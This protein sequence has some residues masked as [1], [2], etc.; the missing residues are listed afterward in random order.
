M[1]ES[2]FTSVEHLPRAVVVHVLCRQL[3]KEEIG[4]LCTAIDQ[5][6]VIA[7]KLSFI[8]DMSKVDYAP[9]MAL[10]VLVGLTKEFQ[11]RG[12]RLIFA[13]VQSHLREAFAITHLHR[14]LEIMPDV[15][16]AQQSLA[17]GN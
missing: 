15:Q 13:A 3:G 7:P 8:L 17:S 5:A 1:S 12:Q 14:I 4:A 6:R 16:A 10:G 11:N 9:S 2:P